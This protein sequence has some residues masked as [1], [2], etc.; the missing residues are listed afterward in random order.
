MCLMTFD[1]STDPHTEKMNDIPL[2]C[3]SLFLPQESSIV[4]FEIPN[5]N[6][7]IWPTHIIQ[8]HPDNKEMSSTELDPG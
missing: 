5:S 4:H 6:L 1:P 3:I 2:L 8:L 7:G